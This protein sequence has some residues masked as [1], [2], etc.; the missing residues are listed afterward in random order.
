M[1][2]VVNPIRKNIFSGKFTILE[3]RENMSTPKLISLRYLHKQEETSI[4][5]YR[6]ATSTALRHTSYTDT[7]DGTFHDDRFAVDAARFPLRVLTGET[8]QTDF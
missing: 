7:T 6:S 1:L 3:I 8:F 4:Y 5:K 2:F